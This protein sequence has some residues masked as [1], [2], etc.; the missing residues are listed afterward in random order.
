MLFYFSLAVPFFG[1]FA[2]VLYAGLLLAFYGLTYYK[3]LPDS[4]AD[5][6]QCGNYVLQAGVLRWLWN[7]FLLFVLLGATLYIRSGHSTPR[8]QFSDKI[9]WIVRRCRTLR[10]GFWPTFAAFDGHSQ[11]AMFAVWPGMTLALKRATVEFERE[12]LIMEDGGTIALDWAVEAEEI[13]EDAPVLILLPGVVGES[14]NPYMKSLIH[15]CRCR[16][17]WRFVCK[18]WRGF[19]GSELTDE[20]QIPEA[21]DARSVKDLYLCVQHVH[22]R[23]PRAKVLGCGFSLGASMMSSL[24]GHYKEELNGVVA[25]VVCLS[26]PC[27]YETAMNR[28]YH[29]KP[30]PYDWIN[31]GVL[32]KNMRKYVES[33]DSRWRDTLGD[34]QLMLIDGVMCQRQSPKEFYNMLMPANAWVWHNLVTIKFLG[35]KTVEEYAREMSLYALK[36]LSMIETP[37]LLLYADDDPVV[38]PYSTWEYEAEAK[39]SPGCVVARCSRGGHCGFFSGPLC[40]SWKNRVTFEFLANALDGPASSKQQQQQPDESPSP[41]STTSR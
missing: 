3:P 39:D 10:E 11:S 7:L 27:S 36:A 8:L 40:R 34:K 9:A 4:C 2:F 35:Y 13:P 16:R 15:Y 20:K 37:T 30:L 29:L 33:P 14:H 17:Q 26:G 5:C 19:G 38:P 41:S 1:F 32:W 18:N 21:W 12:D 25:G 24:V 31:M 22:K 23:Y 28:M 6:L